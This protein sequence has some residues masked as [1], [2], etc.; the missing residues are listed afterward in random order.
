[1]KIELTSTFPRLLFIVRYLPIMD[2]CISIHVYSKGKLTRQAY[3]NDSG[4]LH[5][6]ESLPHNNMYDSNYKEF[7]IMRICTNIKRMSN[8]GVRS[9]SNTDLINKEMKLDNFFYEKFI[10]NNEYTKMYFNR[11]LDCQYFNEELFN[12]IET[13][14]RSEWIKVTKQYNQI[15]ESS[16]HYY[17]NAY[18]YSPKKVSMNSFCSPQ[19]PFN[20]NSQSM[21]NVLC[22]PN[23]PVNTICNAPSNGNNNSLELVLHSMFSKII[24]E[25]RALIKKMIQKE[26]RSCAQN[27]AMTSPL[28]LSKE[29]QCINIGKFEIL[30]SIISY[31]NGVEDESSFMLSDD[32]SNL[33]I[34]LA[35]RK[36][37]IDFNF[38]DMSHMFSNLSFE[39]I[40]KSHIQNY[41]NMPFTKIYQD[42]LTNSSN[43]VSCRIHAKINQKR[44]KELLDIINSQ[45]SEIGI[46]NQGTGICISKS[47][48]EAGNLRKTAIVSNW[49]LS[50]IQQQ[51]LIEKRAFSLG[52]TKLSSDFQSL[53]NEG[54]YLKKNSNNQENFC[55][56]EQAN[57][58]DSIPFSKHDLFSSIDTD[59]NPF[60]TNIKQP[61]MFAKLH[62]NSSINTSRSEKVETPTANKNMVIDN[63][64]RV[65]EETE[66][67]MSGSNKENEQGSY[68]IKPNNSKEA[69]PYLNVI[70]FSVEEISPDAESSKNNLL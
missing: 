15:T 62:N 34:G 41:K 45:I 69:N 61:S 44:E 43:N 19:L 66:S 4:S 8:S 46:G 68:F 25:N 26:K 1:M 64:Y 55:F 65:S 36:A 60:S 51:K 58:R 39:Q 22:S 7:Y 28:I 12:S 24:S 32:H 14:I 6:S 40:Y 53:M 50:K 23:K 42:S 38:N 11:D 17:I 33:D 20:N 59:E 35:R 5:E 10:S 31:L 3:E 21:L 57:L 52:Q 9:H 37:S 29:S 56:S 13:H 47:N 27:F 16:L 70:N 2:G 54:L 67:N 49:E 48:K 18:V 30:K 63:N